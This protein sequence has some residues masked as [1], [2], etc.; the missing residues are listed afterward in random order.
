MPPALSAHARRLAVVLEMLAL[1]A[2]V[3]GAFHLAVSSPIWWLR[4]GDSIVNLAPVLLLAVILLRFATRYLT[5]DDDEDRFSLTRQ[6]VQLASRW[7]LV[8]ALLVP[9]GLISFGWLWIASGN[10]LSDQLNQTSSQLAGLRNRLNAASSEAGLQRLQASTVP[11]LLPPLVPGSIAQQ[12]AQLTEALD[13]NLSR[14]QAN[15]SSQRTSIVV[16]SIPATLRLLLGAT[17]VSA[18]LLTIRRHF[19][20]RCS[21]AIRWPP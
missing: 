6:T 7:A 18:F 2:L 15:L 11:G 19:Q 8:F 16:N 10:T 3:S 14:L 20:E 4:R 17:I 5:P 1:L 9:L 21:D 12:K 13:L